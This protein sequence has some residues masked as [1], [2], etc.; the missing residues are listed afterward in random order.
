[1]T[2]FHFNVLNYGNGASVVVKKIGVDAIASPPLRFRHLPV[3][4]MGRNSTLRFCA[5]PA[6]VEFDVAG[7]EK[8]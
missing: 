8:P 2:L 3:Y 6:A 4:C 1:M 7:F 5:R